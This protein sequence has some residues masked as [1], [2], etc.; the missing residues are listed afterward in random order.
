MSAMSL[1]DLVLSLQRVVDR[2]V[3]RLRLGP[4][5][6]SDGRRFVVVQIDGLSRAVLEGALARRRMPFLA[7]MLRHGHRLTPM[8]VG[9]PTS[10]PTFQLAAMYGV[11]PDIPGFHFHDK[12][13]RQD[14]YFPRRGDAAFVERTQARGRRGIL[15]GGSAYGCVFTGGAVANV[16]T[17]AMLKRPTGR[18]LLRLASAFVL[19]GWVA[20]KGIVLTATEL[21]RAALR[22][23]ANPVGEGAPGWKW[24]AIKI[25][26]SVWVRELFTLAV[27][28]DIYMGVPAVYVNYLDYDV[29]AHAYGPRHPRAFRALRRV[30]RS[31][32][33]LARAMRRVPGYRY[34]LFVL[35]DHGQARCTPYQTLSGGVPFERWLFDQFFA[36]LG[37]REIAPG[38]AERRR[39]AG[40]IEA[41]RSRRVPGLLQRFMNYL[42]S[43]FLRYFRDLPEAREGAGIRVIS[44]GPNAFVYFVDTPEPLTVEQ[45][46]RRCPGLVED[47]SRSRGVGFV[48]VRSATGPVCV[49]RG[50]RYGLDRDGAGPFEGR[51]D[52]DLVIAA[53]RGLMAME[54]AGDIVI[55]GNDAPEGNV[56][57]IGEIGA[58]AGPAEEEM[59]TFVVHPATV[60]M[61]TPLE[62]PARLYDVFQAYR[63]G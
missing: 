8:S 38:R 61:P 40:G 39:L 52:R 60:T 31:I 22:F 47:V 26:M 55:Y 29:A 46:D 15:E 5:P 33:Q 43:D 63:R 37:A 6:V 48:L 49:W 36:P 3:R 17:F 30:D 62:H 4:A 2:L 51:A 23:L 19:L 1:D 18:G 10:T 16:F 41:F 9:L 28:R 45:I 27:S 53:V 25:G 56:T 7:R 34:D 13:R 50:K 54:S 44:A 24:V 20:V 32:R 12:R 11:A 57:Y 42:E 58:H 35:S 14:V 59:Q 21:V